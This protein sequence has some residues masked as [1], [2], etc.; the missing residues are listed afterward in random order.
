MKLQ[1]YL[2]GEIHTDWRDEIIEGCRG[3][4]AEFSSPVTDHA[5]SDDCGA[6]ILGPESDSFWHDRK[7]AGMNAIRTRKAIRDLSMVHS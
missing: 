4:D 3:L 2:S 1:V 5:A 6:A 7:G